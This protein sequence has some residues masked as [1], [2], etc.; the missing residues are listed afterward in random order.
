MRRR[1]DTPITAG[2]ILWFVVTVGVTAGLAIWLASINGL[3]NVG[4]SYTVNAI[5]PTAASLAPGSRV[6]MA[7]VPVGS[8]AT[9]KRVGL[10][11]E[12]TL[13]IT[14][15]NVTPIRTNS[16]VT[17][18]QRT[19]LSE[20]YVEIA[21]GSAR[22]DL[23]SGSTLPASNTNPYVDVDQILSTL[24]GTA[25]TRTRELLQSI[26]GALGDRG[27]K[28]N[29]LLGGGS[30]TITN[31]SRLMEVLA[32]ER[33]QTSQLVAQLGNVSSAVGE[34]D[35]SI[36]QI[37]Q[38]GLG[39]MNAIAD[40]DQALRTLLRA[41]PSTL[42]QV[43]VTTGTLGRVSDLATPVVTQLST[44][45]RELQ[46]AIVELPPATAIGRSVLS[47]LSATAPGLTTTLNDAVSLSQPTPKALAQLTKVICQLNPVIRYAQPYTPDIVQTMVGLGSGTNPYDALSHLLRLA[48][49]IDADSLVGAPPAIQKDAYLLTH[50][51]LF[52]G[53]V[54]SITWDP[55]PKPGMVGKSTSIGV[56][57][58]M[59]PA[60][61][62]STGYK[63]PHILPKC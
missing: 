50:T 36:T 46:P 31:G 25:R 9:I 7:G 29:D 41:L 55:Y 1:S 4:S 6:T 57:D 53:S 33:D 60:Q 48:P 37:G 51:G 63:Y 35:A 23:K 49:T 47:Q 56:P 30:G 8:V 59:G 11:A 22:T 61:V 10:A 21:L 15:S 26:G 24:Q 13:N 12:V 5:L 58:I 27:P 39:A 3:L 28:L 54:G 43:Q 62:P 18:R 32:A 40:R 14:D 52:G 16:R 2:N 44:A 19:P 20:N 42:S 38:Q 17:L 34:R 45:V